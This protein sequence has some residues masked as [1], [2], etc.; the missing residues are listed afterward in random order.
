MDDLRH[1]RLWRDPTDTQP[2]RGHRIVGPIRSRADRRPYTLA[3]VG[4]VVTIAAAAASAYAAYEQGQQQQA[5]AQYNAKLVRNQALQAQYAAEA[6]AKQ[7]EEHTRRLLASQRVAAGASG[8][9]T[10]GSPLAVMMDSAAQ[11]AY[12]AGLIRAG[13]QYQSDALF[14]EAGIQRFYGQQ[15]AEAG[16]LRAGTTLLSGAGSATSAYARYQQTQPS[17]VNPGGGTLGSPGPK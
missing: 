15:A 12:E 5:A 8:V 11:G 1:R 16:T 13:G 3:V 9:T 7:R 4:L 6:Q 14:G 2:R 10:E 17:S